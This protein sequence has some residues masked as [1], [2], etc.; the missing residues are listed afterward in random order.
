MTDLEHAIAAYRAELC[1]HADVATADLD[2]LE[3]HF[4]CA[5]EQLR[6]AGMTSER[7]IAETLARI[8]APRPLSREHVRVR[9]HF[10]TRLSRAR[11]LAAAA[12]LM[13]TYIAF[14]PGA[15]RMFTV[16]GFGINLV[17]SGAMLAA[18]IAGA[19]WARPI[20]LGAVLSSL[21]QTAIDQAIGG[22]ALDLARLAAFAAAAL[23]L[24]PW[25]RGELPVT[26][27]RLALLG[28]VYTAA[29]AL[30]NTQG[31][32][33]GAHLLD[34]PS[35]L[36]A[37]V[38]VGVAGVGGI[39]RARWATLGAAVAA[40]ALALGIPGLWA[41]AVQMRIWHPTPW[42]L[43]MVCTLVLGIACATTSALLGS[44]NLGAVRVR[45]TR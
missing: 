5:V 12:V 1:A 6:S 24:A 33:P 4:R 31:W 10:G 20:M 28:P 7:A 44:A 23:L 15:A 41:L 37:F 25:R 42:L 17:L 11:A 2:E 21:A 22:G 8:G 43:D 14:V 29:D 40:I 9:T 36:V 19:A 18:L 38:A 34:R 32:A 39:V 27:L 30:F 26:A 16:G 3:D 13:P 45:V 35:G